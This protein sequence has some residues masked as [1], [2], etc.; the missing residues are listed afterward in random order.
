MKDETYPLSLAAADQ[1]VE[2]VDVT[3]GRGLRR[4]LTELGFVAGTRLRIVNR[5]TSGPFLIALG[6]MRIALSPGM[7]HK[8]LVR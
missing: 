1:D 5:A 4:R 2:V 6:S 7:A 3:G 8:I